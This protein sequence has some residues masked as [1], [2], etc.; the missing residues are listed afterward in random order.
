MVGGYVQPYP[1][2]NREAAFS[3]L[4]IQQPSVRQPYDIS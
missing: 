4:Y 1:C 2:A 3:R